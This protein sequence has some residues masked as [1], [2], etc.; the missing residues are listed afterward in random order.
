MLEPLIVHDQHDE[1]DAFEADLKSRASTADRDECRC[2]PAFGSTA[3]SDAASVLA[4]KNESP[5]D[6]VRHHQDAF[7]IAQN[8][9]R[10]S[11]VR[12]CHNRVQHVNGGIQPC[13]GVL[14]G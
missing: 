14:P 12:S 6:H 11:F 13:Y 7:G 5:F 8:L 3:G 9:F 2:A 4:A 1:V 10:Y